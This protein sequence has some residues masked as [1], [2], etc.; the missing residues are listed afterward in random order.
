MFFVLSMQKI[1]I[2]YSM[3]QNHQCA[4]TCVCVGTLQRAILRSQTFQLRHKMATTNKHF[5]TTDLSNSGNE[6]PISHLPVFIRLI[7][8]SAC[9]DTFNVDSL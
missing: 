2:S 6:G 8:S 1:D 4:Y 7:P 3:S 5:Q 9:T